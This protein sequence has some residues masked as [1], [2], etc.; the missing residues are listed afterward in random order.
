MRVMT[1][2]FNVTHSPCNVVLGLP[3]L[4]QGLELVMI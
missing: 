1:A 4:G 3:G 2:V